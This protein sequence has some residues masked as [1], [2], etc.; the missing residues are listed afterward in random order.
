MVWAIL[1][2]ILCCNPIAIASIVLSAVAGAEFKRGDFENA[3]KHASLSKKITIAAAIIT[4]IFG[5][6]IN[7]LTNETTQGEVNYHQKQVKLEPIKEKLRAD[8]FKKLATE[9][10][11]NL[12]LSKKDIKFDI[13]PVSDNSD[14]PINLDYIN[15]IRKEKVE[16]QK[17]ILQDLGMTH[18]IYMIND[19]DLTYP[20]DNGPILVEA[21]RK[22]TKEELEKRIR[23]REQLQDLKPS[24]NK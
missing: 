11:N 6:I 13:K 24:Q 8:Y 5:A 20:S 19:E 3:Q 9:A 23:E 14:R 22:I 2:L 16:K 21:P 18:L 4:I 7:S 17:K 10:I 15:A 12:P 1:V